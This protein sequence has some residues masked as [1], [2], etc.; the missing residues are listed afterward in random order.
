MFI[1]MFIM[2]LV[3][4][5]TQ[6]RVV[7]AV[8]IIEVPTIQACLTFLEMTAPVVKG[9]HAAAGRPVTLEPACLQRSKGA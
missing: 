3:A 2:C 4:D 1:P 8:D 5:P 6:C 9:F 7:A